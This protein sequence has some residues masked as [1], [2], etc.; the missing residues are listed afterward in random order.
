M[1]NNHSFGNPW[2]RIFLAP[3]TP[4]GGGGT[5]DDPLPGGSG[6]GADPPNP[7]EPGKTPPGTIPIS[8]FEKLKADHQRLL[9]VH[10]EMKDKEKKRTEE[11]AAKRGEFET[12]YTNVKTE[13]DKALPL[14]EKLT[15]VVQ[16]Q[17]DSKLA[18]LPETFNKELLPQG[19]PAT[20][21]EWLIK[22]EA[23]GLLAPPAPATPPK[24]NGDGTPPAGDGELT[25]WDAIYAK[26]PGQGPQTVPAPAPGGSNLTPPP[27]G[28][29]Q[30][31]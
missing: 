20:Q 18:A 7:D 27:P 19:D 16:T 25:G 22:A 23:S 9:Q 13:L 14:L 2:P 17:L 5:G 30:P 8:E 3:D 28:A 24:G 4:P 15:G 11:E 21:L 26:K 1:L 6:D 31:K 12:L 29:P 10:T